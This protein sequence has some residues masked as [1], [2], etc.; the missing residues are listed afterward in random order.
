MGF[1]SGGETKDRRNLAQ[2]PFTVA[3]QDFLKVKKW[4]G[5]PFNF[6]S[7]LVSNIVSK[8]KKSDFIIVSRVDDARGTCCD[9]AAGGLFQEGA[10]DFECLGVAFV[11]RLVF[12]QAFVPSIF[13]G[14][15]IVWRLLTRAGQGHA[16]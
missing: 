8:N 6:F 13:G 4:N 2:V 9:V 5:A 15:G 10:Q 16:A 11:L 1:E 7:Y 12:T 14:V 3:F